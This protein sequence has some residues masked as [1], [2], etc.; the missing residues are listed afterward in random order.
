MNTDHIIIEGNTM[1]CTHCG[2]K[3]QI[4]MPTAID[5]LLQQ[6]DQFTAAH[7][8]CQALP[9]AEAVMS[10]YVKG[11]DHG[12]DYI[13]NEIQLWSTKHAR[14]VGDLLAHLKM[15]SKS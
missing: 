3:Q 13:V 8:H 11:F 2:F 12:C 9:P 6:M 1:R 7:K 5:N 4:K 14:D 15:E 10:D